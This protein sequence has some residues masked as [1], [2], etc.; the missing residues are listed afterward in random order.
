M[1]MIAGAILLHAL[2]VLWTSPHVPDVPPQV[3]NLLPYLFGGLGTLLMV[4]GMAGAL[5]QVAR[6]EP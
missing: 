2:V 5:R 3:A 1:P 4:L 6:G